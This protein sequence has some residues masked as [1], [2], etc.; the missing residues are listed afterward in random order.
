MTIKVMLVD[1]SA[2]TRGILRRIIDADP[3]IEIA[4]QA[5]NGRQA[6]DMLKRHPE[7]TMVLLDVEM[8]EMDGITAL[9]ELLKL[10]PNLNV[11]MVSTLTSRG[12][13]VSFRALRLGAKDYVPKPSTTSDQAGVEDFRREIIEKIKAISA[14]SLRQARP[15]SLTP[16]SNRAADQKAKPQVQAQPHLALSDRKIPH[17]A[18]H[19]LAF[20]S[21]TGGPQALATVLK[22][23][24]RATQV[25]VF[26]SQ[27]MPPAFTGM[28]A[29]HL[30]QASQYTASEATD[31]QSVRAGHIYVAPGGYH[32]KIV[33]RGTSLV[34]KLT[35]D[36][37]ENYCRPSVNPMLRS[38]ADI[39]GR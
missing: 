12:A 32:M 17:N 19:A 37:P 7:V 5:A 26:V 34:I 3:D 18:P 8:P 6:I 25:P 14:Q 2:T 30:E 24:D 27:H 4:V 21:S 10:R 39:Y 16:E 33:R 29:K 9:P 22:G 36:P 23:L 28:L 31:G 1:D 11:L 38:L 20:G 15:A 13:T 35:E